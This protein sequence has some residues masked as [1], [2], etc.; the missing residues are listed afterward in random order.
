[1]RA[2]SL[3]L[4]FLVPLMSGAREL[5]Q[6]P[7]VLVF[8]VGAPLAVVGQLSCDAGSRFGPLLQ[9]PRLLCQLD[10]DVWNKRT[11]AW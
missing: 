4:L 3:V 8:Q 11:F 10:A 9:H 6:S 5:I 2:Y 1:M 7:R